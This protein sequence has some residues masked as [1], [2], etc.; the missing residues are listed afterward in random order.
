MS[1]FFHSSAQ[2]EDAKLLQEDYY[3]TEEVE[4]EKDARDIVQTLS[5][6]TRKDLSDPAIVD[7]LKQQ[8]TRHNLTLI[9]IITLKDRFTIQAIEND[10]QIR[11]AQ[12]LAKVEQRLLTKVPSSTAVEEALN[13]AGAVHGFLVVIGKLVNTKNRDDVLQVF[14]AL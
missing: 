9:R 6:S 1:R 2:R 4:L 3:K 7:N 10:V 14:V 8:L 12:K 13:P 5:L 11:I